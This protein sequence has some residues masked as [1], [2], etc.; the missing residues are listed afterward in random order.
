[1]VG[2]ESYIPYRRP[3]L[4]K[5]F[6]ADKGGLES[7]YLK[8]QAA[9]DNHAIECRTGARV[10]R[11]MRD[12]KQVQLSGGELL[13][14]EMLVLAT[15]GRARA[16]PVAGSE[17]P[18]V[19]YVRTIEDIIGL[20]ADFKPGARLVIIGGGYIG[21]EAAAVAIDFGLEVTVVE[22]MERVLAR[23][24]V[25]AISEFY[26]RAH[27]DRGVNLLTATGVESFHGEQR[28]EQVRLSDQRILDADLVIVG[29]GMIPNTELA[30]DAGL[31]VDANG[32]V[33]DRA[34]RTS[35]PNIFSAG[36]CTY[37][38]NIFYGRHMR[39][40][41]VPNA[42]AQA[43]IVAAGIC[44]ENQAY[45]AVPWFWSDQY[46]LRLQMVGLADGYDQMI[47]RGEMEA[48]S[49]IFFYLKAGVVISAD[50]LNRPQEFM[51]A[52][53]LVTERA[54]PPVDRLV[55]EEAPLKLLLAGSNVAH[56]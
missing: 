4:S 12:T 38:E 42:T 53:K 40:E 24:A 54:Q 55:D 30:K 1:M 43:R 29:I 37:H 50:A 49:F 33:V 28:V 26:A 10:E 32:I 3:P 11:V 41:S 46:D 39:V 8:P 20:K 14:Y 21:L 5:A 22:A 2:D 51:I 25:P 6:L 47:V 18:N 34:A 56:K 19:H 44:G 48:N 23:V 7:L 31:E 9:Y 45:A 15:G 17:L 13:S 16:L 35:D 52:K 27:R 36:D